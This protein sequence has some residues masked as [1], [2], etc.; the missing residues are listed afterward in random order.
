[1]GHLGHSPGQ[2]AATSADVGGRGRVLAGPGLF[3]QVGQGARAQ[4]EQPAGEPFLAGAGDGV[5]RLR[6][7]GQGQLRPA[8]P[9][10]RLRAALAQVP[11]MVRAWPPAQ[12][13]DSVE[14]C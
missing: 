14:S 8:E 5:Q 9:Q 7:V 3:G 6:H 13:D 1:M 12:L 2:H 10:L 11:G 4:A